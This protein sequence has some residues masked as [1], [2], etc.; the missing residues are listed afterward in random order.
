MRSSLRF[1]A[2]A[3]P[4]AGA[5]SGPAQVVDRFALFSNVTST[6]PT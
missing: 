6:Q 1:L 2:P 4:F 3:L 5:L